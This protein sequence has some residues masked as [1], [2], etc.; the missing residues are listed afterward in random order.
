MYHL[1]L[2]MIFRISMES[3]LDQYAGYKLDGVVHFRQ[4][5]KLPQLP[6]L[7]AAASTSEEKLV[8]EG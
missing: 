1:H 5:K 2:T 7:E 4:E 6:I 3:F 8:S